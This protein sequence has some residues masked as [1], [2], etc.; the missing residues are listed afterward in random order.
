MQWLARFIYSK[1]LGWKLIGNTDFSKNTIQKAIIIVA[2]H[3]SWHDFYVCILLRAMVNVKTHF[4]GKK[5]LF[6]Y[7]FG[8]FLRR[9]GGSPVNRKLNEN[10]VETIVQLFNDKE[11]FRMA[12]APEGTRKKVLEWRSGFYFIAKQAKVPIIMLSLDY[13]NKENKVSA[14]FYPT[15]DME[16]DFK[17]MHAFFKGVKGKN[18]EYS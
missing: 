8:W 5:S 11:E 12:L 13:K 6:S 16:E 1:I 15:F 10:K 7:P 18:P 17:F 9:L 14:P 4:I 2:P 3:T